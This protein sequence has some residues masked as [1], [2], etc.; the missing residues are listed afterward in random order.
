MFLAKIYMSKLIEFLRKNRF[1]NEYFFNVKSVIL[2]SKSSFSAWKSKYI[3]DILRMKPKIGAK[4]QISWPH[5]VKDW[6][7]I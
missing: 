1:Q 2:A 4:I 7:K 3:F 5:F 6:G